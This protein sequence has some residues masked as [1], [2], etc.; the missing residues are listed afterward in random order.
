[1][2]IGMALPC[3]LFETVI[4][5][6]ASA[7]RT[8]MQLRSPNPR[9][10]TPAELPGASLDLFCPAQLLSRRHRVAEHAVNFRQPAV[11]WRIGRVYLHGFAH[12]FGLKGEASATGVA[13][14]PR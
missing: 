11:H 2:E 12:K 8:L 14:R 13:C 5:S 4:S 7:T 9:G 10:D 1:M 3:G 6:C